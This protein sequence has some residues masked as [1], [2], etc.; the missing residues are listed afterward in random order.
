MLT[1]HS[2]NSCMMESGS[3]VVMVGGG[4]PA[5]HRTH[6]SILCVHVEGCV[7]TEGEC[8]GGDCDR[9][10]PAHCTHCIHSEAVVSEGGEG[11]DG[12]GGVSSSHCHITH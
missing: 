8:G 6:V 1:S 11:R 12:D 9:S 5:G 4:S 10:T 2:T 3:N 7:L